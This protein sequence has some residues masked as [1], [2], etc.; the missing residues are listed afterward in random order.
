[1]SP[2]KIKIHR[3][4]VVV[5]IIIICLGY[6][7]YY[8][9][10]SLSKPLP[11]AFNT[12]TYFEFLKDVLKLEVKIEDGIGWVYITNYSAEHAIPPQD[13]EWLITCSTKIIDSS[14]EIV[15]DYRESF[16]SFQQIEPGTTVKF[17][18]DLTIPHGTMVVRLA[19]HDL[20]LL[21][22]DPNHNTFLAKLV[23]KKASF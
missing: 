1:M 10:S 22:T 6:L 9:N 5:I 3:T 20:S 12:G 16:T 7:V 15:G 13:L 8:Q 11:P 2:I 4:A 21:W 14:G 23:E 19:Y 18:Y 17:G